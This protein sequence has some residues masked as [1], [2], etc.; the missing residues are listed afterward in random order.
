MAH[1]YRICILDVVIVTTNANPCSP[2]RRQLVRHSQPT[3]QKPTIFIQ[4]LIQLQ[5]ILTQLPLINIHH[6]EELKNVPKLH[7]QPIN[8][9]HNLDKYNAVVPDFGEFFIQLFFLHLLLG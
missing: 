5:Q 6:D 9:F 8:N 2:S 7:Q 1:F 3:S 4:N